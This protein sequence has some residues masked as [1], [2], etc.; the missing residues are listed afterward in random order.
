MKKSM[1]T[2][3]VVI[4]LI[5]VLFFVWIFTAKPPSFSNDSSRSSGSGN[6]FTSL[7]IS[8]QDLRYFVKLKLLGRLRD[9]T[10]PEHNPITIQVP[11]G[12][13]VE[14][15]T[16]FSSQTGQ[17]T[18]PTYRLHPVNGELPNFTIGRIALQSGT[19]E[20]LAQELYDGEKD[21]GGGDV[22]IEEK[23]TL[24]SYTGTCVRHSNI[25]GDNRDYYI[26]QV[27][28]TIG[29]WIF[30]RTSLIDGERARA[31]ETLDTVFKTIVVDEATPI[32]K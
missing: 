7:N 9:A 12:Y 13:T 27:S 4:F 11:N 30:V 15:S 22:Q 28:P 31:L 18:E 1:F 26:L 5:I 10:Q 17:K 14:V 21:W 2:V 29:L 23:C 16:G 32:R 19:I 8:I 3:L 20:K 6:S 25:D 24:G